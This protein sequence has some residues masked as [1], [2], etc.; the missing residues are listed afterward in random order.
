M[1]AI[2]VATV[3]RVVAVPISCAVAITSLF[4]SAAQMVSNP[5]SSAWR[6]IV[7]TSCALQPTP[8]ITPNPSRSA[9]VFSFVP[10]CKG[11]GADIVNMRNVVWFFHQFAWG[12]NAPGE[13]R[14]PGTTARNCQKACAVGRLLHWDVR[15]RCPP[16]LPL[17][18]HLPAPKCD[19]Y[20]SKC[21]PLQR[22][23]WY[24]CRDESCGAAACPPCPPE[25]RGLARAGRT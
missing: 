9:M 23:G 10:S 5:A 14:P 16:P 18:R 4:T 7:W 8:G 1:L 6:A 17:P 25:R 12:P 13:L 22:P 20:A 19:G 3:I 24:G 11:S 15:L 21:Q 2:H